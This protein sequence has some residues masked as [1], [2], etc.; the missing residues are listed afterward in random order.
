MWALT[1]L[2]DGTIVSGESSGRVHFWDGATGAMTADF[3]QHA[4]DVLAVAA[5]PDGRAVYAAGVDPRIAVFQLLPAAPGGAIH[6]PLPPSPPLPQTTSAAGAVVD[7]RELA[8]LSC[9]QQLPRL[10]L[11]QVHTRPRLLSRCRAHYLRGLLSRS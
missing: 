11:V 6:W 7:G 1:V 9:V 4:A 2:P 5:S 10:M 3:H 8:L